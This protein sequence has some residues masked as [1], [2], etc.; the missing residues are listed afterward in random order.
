MVKSLPTSFTDFHPGFS[1]ALEENEDETWRS[2]GGRVWQ[3]DG[4]P[5]LDA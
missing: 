1:T 4:L 5:F 3:R 2:V